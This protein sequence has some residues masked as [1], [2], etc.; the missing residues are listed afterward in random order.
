MQANLNQHEISQYAARRIKYKAEQLIGT[1]GYTQS[2]REDIEQEMM[3]DLL[4]R[5][6]KYDKT[7][8]T[9]KTFIARVIDRKISM[10]IRARECPLRDY[11]REGCSL[12]ERVHNGRSNVATIERAETL[13]HEEL[14]RRF[15][16][17]SRSAQEIVDFNH[18]IAM[19]LAGLP[20][21]LRK[22]CEIL[23]TGNMV[24]ATREMGIRR[25][26]LCRL[27]GAI[28]GLFKNEGLQEYL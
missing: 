12:N 17:Q 14:D 24:E 20:E 4:T 18:D 23:M 8:A 22:L 19:V 15:G 1:A 28:R 26:S 13:A 11:R 25:R 2:D 9:L 16:R 10:M 6:P 27:V 21:S 7:K 3:L 5:V